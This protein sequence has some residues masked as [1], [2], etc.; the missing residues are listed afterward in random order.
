M[1]PRV[2]VLSKSTKG[3]KLTSREIRDSLIATSEHGDDIEVTLQLAV[4]KPIV[5]YDQIA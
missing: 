2:S 1:K 5:E 3:E 4:L